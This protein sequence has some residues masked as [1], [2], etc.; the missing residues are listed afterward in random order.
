MS[1]FNF[2]ALP[3][4]TEYSTVSSTLKKIKSKAKQTTPYNSIES[5]GINDKMTLNGKET[6][7]FYDNHKTNRIIGFAS[8][9]SLKCL[10]ESKYHHADGTFHTTA[11]YTSQLYVIHAFFPSK[12]FE[13][14][15]KVW[16]KRMIPC[17]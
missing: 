14:D 13:G 12:D 2:T 15:G 3:F 1:K 4:T 10:S 8:P 5:I 11:R 16:S 17:A 7:N 6:F 9:T